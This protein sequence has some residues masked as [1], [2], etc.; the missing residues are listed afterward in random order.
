[1]Q[2]GDKTGIIEVT[3]LGIL[4]MQLSKIKMSGFKSFVDPTTIH[5]PS[6]LVAVVGPNGCG[7]SNVI[8]AITW[9][10]GESSPK[11]LRGESLTDVIFNGSTARKP[12]GQASVELVFDNSDGSLGGEYAG[13]AEI[14]VKRMINRESDA[15]YF[16]N[17]VRCRKRDIIGLFLGTGLGPRSYS[18]IGQNMISRIT[19]AKPDELRTYLEEAAG[20]SKY[21]ERRHE[22]EL[23]INHTKDNLAR[24]NDLLLELDKQLS[25]L[26]HQA[27]VAEKYKTL[28]QQERKLRA[29]LYGIQWQQLDTRLADHTLKLQCEETA[30][31]ARNSDL[32]HTDREMEQVRQSQ[33]EANEAFQEVQ[34]QFYAAGNEITRIE[35]AILHHQEKQQQW[36]TD[37]AQAESDYESI[38]QESEELGDQSQEL[39][40]DIASL[41]PQM[42]E[43]TQAFADLK[44]KLQAAEENTQ[45]LQN[46]WDEFNQSASKTAQT[47]Q[48]EQARIQHLE[49]SQ[50]S[51]RQRNEQLQR[52][53]QQFDF[54]ALQD[55][56]ASYANQ[57][58]EAA[59]QL[60]TQQQQLSDTKAETNAAQTTLQQANTQ[61]DKT[62]SELQQLLGQQASLQALQQT[63][64]GQRGHAA[65]PW[66][67]QHQLDNKPRLAQQMTVAKGWEIAVEKVLGVHLQAICVDDADAII[68]NLDGFKSGNL[69][70]F[71]ANAKAG[72]RATDAKA[73]LLI[74][75]VESALPLDSLLAG[76]YVADSKEQAFALCEQLQAHESVITRDGIWLNPAWLNILRDEDPAAGVFEREQALKSLATKIESLRQAQ[77]EC[78]A[79][80]SECKAKIASLEQQRE[81]LQQA[82]NQQQA[83]AAQINAQHKAKQQR[84]SE[85]SAQAERFA[86]EQKNCQQQLEQVTADLAKAKSIWE[87]ALKEMETHADKRESLIEERESAKQHWLSM[88]DTFNQQKDKMHALEIR[89]QTAK[90]QQTALQQNRMRLQTQLVTLQER[91]QTLQTELSGMQSI[92]GLNDSLTKALAQHAKVDTALKAA[93]ETVNGLDQSCRQLEEKR[94]ITERELN[95]VRNKL[96]ALRLEWQGWK[97]KSDTI[98]EQA[99]EADVNLEEVVKELTAD[100]TAESWQAQLD[101]VTARINRLG[102]INLVAIEEYNTCLE[103]KDYLDKQVADL[104]AGLATLEDAMQKI[105]RET[106]TRFKETFDKVNGRFQSLFPTIFGGGKAWLELNAENLLE[107][108]VTMMA[109]PPGKRN[110]SIYLLSGGEKSLTAIA[111][112]FSIFYL[113]PAPFC[114]L[115][116]VDAALDDANVV[117]FTHLVKSMAEKTQFIFISHN[118][119]TIEM[120]EQLIGVTMN[121]PGVSRL[122]SVDIEKAMSMV[123]NG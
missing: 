27:N 117:R 105:D 44:Q 115:D 65:H 33:R 34:G 94:Q 36:Q 85:L 102:A 45:T 79:K 39:A 30:L 80:I 47:A 23:R 100:M 49:Q 114:L 57:S 75:K 71:I 62:R 91:K 88:R 29:E 56:I 13:F 15:A 2:F 61:L 60:A 7:K 70:V 24:V 25:H 52:D 101:Q 38:Q 42:T 104:Q 93:R 67:K 21:K 123:E 92:D 98:M 108:G 107:A 53:Q 37:L 99:K 97:V 86:R 72:K 106:R 78:E 68:K 11:Y 54:T 16:L 120:G 89:L 4:S 17:G 74:D 9:V 116:E 121:E 5:L 64:L 96:E 48:V 55:E 19:E 76:I 112:I 50:N 10:M 87:A 69:S 83:S 14:S 73:D 35:Q 113:N 43:A 3:F 51:L 18:I 110:S 41:T 28:K 12:I 122:V 66:M 90:S 1:M 111:F 63:A 103:R 77:S 6:K 95:Q 118:K 22:T 8:D 119:I 40:E 81:Q 46:R 31:E 58:G 82:C 20:I 59:T 26:K 84:L 109:C 32:T